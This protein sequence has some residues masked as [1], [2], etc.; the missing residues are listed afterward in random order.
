MG[1]DATPEVSVERLLLLDNYDS[2]TYN[3]AQA[4]AASAPIQVRVVRCDAWT[5]EQVLD[6]APDYLVISPGPGAPRSERQLDSRPNHGAG[7][8]TEAIA[9]LRGRIPILGVCLGHQLLGSL[10]GATVT[11]A[12]VPVHGKPSRVVHDDSGI[13]AGLP[14]PLTVARYHSLMIDESTLPPEARVVARTDDG[15][16]MAMELAGEP[17]WGVQFHPESFMTP[18]GPELLGRFLELGRA[19]RLEEV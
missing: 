4:F 3:L 12:P 9:A 11:R 14:N 18:E 15:I 8:S 17:T 19:R 5:L 7:V 2:F 16:V 10:L 6:E 1:E 13:F